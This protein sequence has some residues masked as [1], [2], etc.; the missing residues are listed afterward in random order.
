MTKLQQAKTQL[1]TGKYTCVLCADETICTTTRRGVKPLVLW[2]EQGGVPRGFCAADKVVGKA[3]AFLYCLLGA[4]AVYADVMSRSAKTVL[5][6]HGIQTQCAILT[7]YI[8]NRTKTGICPFEEAVL[9]IEE[10]EQARLAIHKKMRE[11][12][13]S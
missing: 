6:T 11:L 1:A 13:I 7:D 9:G 5:E 3:T 4:K 2:L 8:E 12:G 10:P